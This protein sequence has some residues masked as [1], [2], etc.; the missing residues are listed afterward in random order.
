[1]GCHVSDIK[2]C[3]TLPQSFTV[4]FTYSKYALYRSNPPPQPYPIT[5]S[6]NGMNTHDT[7]PTI[8]AQILAIDATIM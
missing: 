4:I 5:S 3:Q 7:G 2:V 8:S 6:M 1:M